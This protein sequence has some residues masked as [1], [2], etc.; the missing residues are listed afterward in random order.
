MSLNNF[1]KKLNSLPCVEN[2]TYDEDE[3]YVE[4]IFTGN[5]NNYSSQIGNVR[6]QFPD[7]NQ[8]KEISEENRTI[9]VYQ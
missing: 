4:V 5:P 8:V 1:S 9:L 2:T 6:E 3:E 7:I